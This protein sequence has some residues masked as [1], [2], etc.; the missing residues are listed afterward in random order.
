MRFKVRHL[1][2][3]VLWT[4]ATYGVLSI[5]TLDLGIDHPLCGAWG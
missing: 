1:I 2:C 4:A 3:L 5:A